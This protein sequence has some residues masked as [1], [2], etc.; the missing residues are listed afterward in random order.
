M[1]KSQTSDTANAIVIPQHHSQQLLVSKH[2]KVSNFVSSSIN[3]IDVDHNVFKRRMDEHGK[4][5][6]THEG[7]KE[8]AFGDE[9]LLSLV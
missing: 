1:N 2:P 5:L 3:Q 7:Q 4:P 8:G 9:T 6:D